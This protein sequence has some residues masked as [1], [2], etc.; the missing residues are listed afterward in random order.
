MQEDVCEARRS[1]GAEGAANVDTTGF[2]MDAL[3]ACIA[4]FDD[5]GLDAERR[6]SSACMSVSML[7]CERC[8]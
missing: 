6:E 3:A 5:D 4:V 8:T 2:G 7:P 1:L